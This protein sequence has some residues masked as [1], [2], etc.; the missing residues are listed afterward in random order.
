ME[1]VIDGHINPEKNME[2]DIPQRL[3]VSPILFI[4]YISGVFD[5]VSAI[6][7]K[8]ISISFIDDLRFLA[9]GNLVWEVTT[10]LE[11]I[12]ETILR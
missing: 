3:P 6:L 10:S 2:T 11:K 8:T 1:I 7:S 9:S 5:A 12:R 4:I